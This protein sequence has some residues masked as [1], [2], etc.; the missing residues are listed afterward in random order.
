MPLRPV[1][2]RSRLGHP[3]G[4]PGGGQG[5]PTP[6]GEGRGNTGTDLRTGQER[7]HGV[8]T[9]GGI[10]GHAS[11][12]LHAATRGCPTWLCTSFSSY[13]HSGSTGAGVTYGVS[14]N[15]WAVDRIV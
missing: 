2:P 3:G 13:I 12:A 11:S 1:T 4:Q 15:G 5:V 9:P 10:S 6:P 8:P 14:A 7:M